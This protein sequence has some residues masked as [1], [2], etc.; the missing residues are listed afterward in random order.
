[1]QGGASLL[2]RFTFCCC[3]QLYYK[4]ILPFGSSVGH[5]KSRQILKHLA[6]MT[7][8]AALIDWKSPRLP[9]PAEACRDPRPHLVGSCRP[10]RTSV[11]SEVWMPVSASRMPCSV[12]MSSSPSTCAPGRVLSRHH[13]ASGT[14]PR[15]APTLPLTSALCPRQQSLSIASARR[16]AR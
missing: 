5:K 16:G 11:C 1:M 7:V 8:L 6:S 14:P 10:W 13:P 15:P 4:A 12:L 2:L 9:Q 3:S